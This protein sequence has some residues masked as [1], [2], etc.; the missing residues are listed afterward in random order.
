M[1]AYKIAW[2]KFDW[3]FIWKIKTISNQKIR[4]LRAKALCEIIKCNITLV[5]FL[6][7]IKET[8]LLNSSVRLETYHV[9]FDALR[10]VP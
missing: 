8:G 4:H 5:P 3:G 1:I 6:Q 2:M 7:G 9:H 10:G